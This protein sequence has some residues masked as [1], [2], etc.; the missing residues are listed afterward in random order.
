[1]EYQLISVIEYPFQSDDLR[2]PSV[3]EDGLPLIVEGETVLWQGRAAIKVNFFNGKIWKQAWESPEDGHVWLTDQRLAYTI[4]KFDKGSTYIG[5]LVIDTA[6][7]TAVS[8]ARAAGRRGG[9]VASGQLG[10]LWVKELAIFG[11]K[12]TMKRFVTEKNA[13]KRRR[14]LG[15][16]L[17]VEDVDF[18]FLLAVGP[19]RAEEIAHD[20]AR[21]AAVQRLALRSDALTSEQTEALESIKADPKFEV[22]GNAQRLRFPGALKVGFN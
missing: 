10:H 17:Q 14:K 15:V 8:K 3:G 18:S 20:W 11:E 16:N 4:K 13:L 2:C 12:G 7:M 21:A 19:E 9:K 6:I 5:G 1:M 22:G